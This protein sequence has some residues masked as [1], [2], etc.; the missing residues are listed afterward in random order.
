[1]PSPPRQI[2]RVMTVSLATLFLIAAVLNLGAKIPLGSSELTFASPSTSTAE[3]EIAIALVLLVATALSSLYVYGG[4][5]LFATVGILEGLLS[6]DVQGLARSIH[7]VM[8]PLAIGG[9]ILVVVDAKNTYKARRYQTAGQRTRE[10]VTILQFFVGGLVTLGGAAYAR[11]GTYPFGTAMGLV[12]LAVGLT[13]LFAGYSFL[14]RKH[15]SQNFLIGI[16]YLTIGYSAFSE[17]IAEI[18]ALL[19]PGINDALIGTIIAIIVSATIIYILFSNKSSSSQLQRD[20][21]TSIR[22]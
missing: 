13:G 5:Y 15:W 9:W 8:V 6:S 17:T 14:R 16:N 1:M 19:P 2:I 4:A 10:I 22:L 20:Q 7:E 12:H 11:S 3:F 21:Q 18:Y